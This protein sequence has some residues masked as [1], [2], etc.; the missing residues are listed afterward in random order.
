M[1]QHLI[2][3]LDGKDYLVEPGTN[4]LEFIKSR[5]TF[6]PSICYNESL[7]PIQTCDTCTVEIDGRIERA[8]S[9][10]IDRP[11]VVNT[12][13]D[14]VQTS[15]KE[16]LDRILE[17]HQLYCTVCD[18][19]NGDCEIHN[20]MD[21]WGL[22]HQTYEYKEKPYEKD[23]GPFYRYAPNQCI[24]CGRCVEVCQDVQVNETLT[25]DWERQQ[26]R[27]IWDN[28]TSIND[29]SCVGCGQCATVCPCNAMMEVNMEGNAGYMTDLEPG[30]LAAMIDLTKKAEPGYGPLFAVSDSEA[31]MREER[32]EKTKTV[33]TYCGV[34]CSF[35]VWTKDRE[36]LKVQPQPE[37]PANHISTCVKG[38][39]GWDYVDSDERLTQPLVRK[40]N[41]FVEVGWEEAINVIADN[42]KDIRDNK[43]SDHLA[44]ISSSKATNEE[45]YLMQKLARQVIGTNNVDNCSRYCQAPATK[46]L[47]RT[48]GHGGDSGSIDDLEKADMV[49]LIGTNTAEAHPVIASRIKRGHKLYN[50]TLNVFDIR[51]HEMA[52]RADNFYQPKPGTDLVWL[53]AVA[54]YI[55]DHDKHDKAF[56]DEWVDDFDEYYSTLETFTMDYAEETTGIPKEDLIDFAEQM[57]AANAVSICWAMGVTQQDIGS[58]TSTAIS[59][60]L[61]VTG[62]YRRPGTGAYPLRGHNNVQGCSDMGSMPDKFTGYQNVTDDEVRAKFERAYG[63]TLPSEVG[64]DNHQMMEGI[65]A[66]E[67]NSLYLYGEDTGIVDSNINFVQ[68]ALEK[69]DFLVVQDAFF[70]YTASFADVV[71]PASPSLEKSGTFTNTERRIQ[72]L[73]QALDPKGNSKPDWQIIQAI[74]KALDHDWGYTDPSEIMDEIASLTP[75]YS[76]V[77]Y[78]RLEG[79]NSLQWPV[80]PDGSDEPTLYMNGFNFDNGKAKLYPLTFDNFFK[81]DDVYDLHVNNGRLLEH[82]HEGNMTYRVPGISYKV[83]NAFVEISP[84]LAE[85]RDIHEGAEVKLIS[86]TGEAEL[87]VHVTDRVKGKEIYIPLNSNSSLIGEQAGAINLLT[88]SDVDKDSDTPSYKRTS[89]RMEVKT[90]RGKSP[91]NPTNFRVDKQRKPQY[92]VRVQDK[93]ERDDYI[94]PGNQVNK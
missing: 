80:A 82:F 39:F 79:Y 86:D 55:I 51:K 57:A 54:K 4:L 78:D 35:D 56:I 26:P 8:C 23:Y 46:G 5:D 90:R 36:V 59:N 11:M 47:F 49:V 15:Q 7:G 13:N 48:V 31:A 24:L 81:Q 28:D 16:A 52:Q 89:C 53:S 50:N 34:G 41:E 43:G 64:K 70:T 63:T 83:P 3:T 12:Q 91:L 10:T 75:L 17:K 73:Y 14:R 9:T 6:V 94:F 69:V 37:S 72:R 33:C 2:V 85:D 22:Q 38:K 30:S 65:H 44:F 20:T 18:Y 74:A 19:N 29:S 21:Q 87:T 84:E 58:D 1:Q 88:N 40:G 68:S 67:I 77:N 25:I 27:V 71:L 62:N 42:F 93:W 60:L 66:N 76:G 61:L 45:S 32:I 92:S